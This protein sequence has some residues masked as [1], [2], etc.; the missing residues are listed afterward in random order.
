MTEKENEENQFNVQGY[1]I[2]TILKRLEAATSRLEDITIFQEAAH[3]VDKASAGQVLEA[4]S[5]GAAVG[6]G[7]GVAGA[8]HGDRAVKEA[9]KIDEEIKVSPSI[10]AFEKFIKT[11]VE[12][13]AEKSLALDPLVGEAAALFADAFRSQLK[14]LDIVSQSKKAD[15]QD[16]NFSKILTPTN[17]QIGKIIEIKDANRRSPF[18][19]HL[20][21]IGEGAPVLGWVVTDAP[22]SFIPEFRDSAKFW[23]DRVLKEFKKESVH[24]EWVQSFL[25]VFEGLLGFVKE[26]HS[27]GLSWNSNGKNLSEVL[28]NLEGSEKPSSSAPAPP[29]A[30]GPPPPP[31]PPPADLYN[32]APSTPAAPSINAVFADLNR[33]ENVTSGLRKVS[34]S[35]MTHKN[36]GLRN[37]AAEV[38]SAKKPSPPKKP[39]SLSTRKPSRFE[40][41]DGT[42]WVVEN[43]IEGEATEPLIIEA[44]MHQLVFIGNCTGV[45]VQIKG[46]ANALSI[47]ETKKTSVVIDNLISGLDVI[48]SFKFGIQVLGVVPIISVDKSDEGAIYLSQQSVDA[49]SQIF[50]SSTT[51]LNVNVPLEDDFVEIA[52]PE[53]LQHKVKG[54]RL[55]TNVVE[56]AG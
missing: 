44:E 50:T 38:P 33:G 34:K 27:S 16:P 37:L 25:G 14:F 20:N 56:H 40:L 49:D 1:N 2:V 52:V 7:A 42:K 3:K 35:E 21:T 6:A 47:S 43:Y 29:S 12:P 15:M 24:V 11:Y 41:L 17:T 22:V 8:V 30:G 31:P 32:A 23:S 26:Y 4:A 13:F 28:R 46:K 10:A 9:V 45:T 36:P 54:G 55:V 48:K 5:V 51:A 18:F 39:T 53:Q 19:N